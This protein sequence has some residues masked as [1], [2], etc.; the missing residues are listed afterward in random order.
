V[1][2]PTLLYALKLE[3]W[4]L[5]GANCGITNGVGCQMREKGKDKVICANNKKTE[6]E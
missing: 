6:K 2:T 5:L 4:S 1:A 3:Q